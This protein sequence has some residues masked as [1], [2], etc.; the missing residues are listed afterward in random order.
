MATEISRSSGVLGPVGHYFI[1]LPSTLTWYEGLPS[2]HT[3]VANVCQNL[4]LCSHYENRVK[5][6]SS[7]GQLTLLKWDSFEVQLG[8]TL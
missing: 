3:P 8:K 6:T 4:L 2:Y 1:P 7:L 5:D